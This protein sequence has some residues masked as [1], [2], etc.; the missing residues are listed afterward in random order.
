[1]KLCW[2]FLE[3]LASVAA[4][5]LIAMLLAVEIT[6][7]TGLTARA[8][9]IALDRVLPEGDWVVDA[10][11]LDLGGPSIEI[12]GLTWSMD[13][14]ELGRA[15]R[16]A[17][18]LSPFGLGRPVLERVV[19]RGGR[20][21]LSPALVAALTPR[22]GTADEDGGARPDQLAERA[23]LEIYDLELR[24]AASDTPL[25]TLDLRLD[26]I[27]EGRLTLVASARDR[28]GRTGRLEGRG[29]LYDDG[30]STIDVAADDLP[31]TPIG[32]IFEALSAHSKTERAT[33]PAFE[34]TGRLS[35][36][37]RAR[38]RTDR[39]DSI[40]LSFEAL[41][42]AVDASAPELDLTEGAVKGRLTWRPDETNDLGHVDG[43]IQGDVVWDGQRVRIGWRG[44]D[45]MPGEPDALAAPFGDIHLCTL[46]RPVGATV[47]ALV[48]RIVAG[49]Q[50]VVDRTFEA[51]GA[52]GAADA[53]LGLR[54]R[55]AVR[56][57]EM[58][59]TWTSDLALV[60][61]PNG[62]LA[63]SIDGWPNA[64][65]E[66][67]GFP[68]PVEGLEG[69][70]VYG[71]VGDGVR[72][73][74]LGVL[75]ADGYVPAAAGA[76]RPDART[77][78]VHVEGWLASPLPPD[79]RGNRAAD[80]RAPMHF[81][82]A[83]RDVPI[84]ERLTAAVFATGAGIDLDAIVGPRAGRVAEARVEIE[85]SPLLEGVVVSVD[86]T[87]ADLAGHLAEDLI[88][89]AFDFEEVDGNV[90]VRMGASTGGLGGD[91]DVERRAFGFALDLDG[92]FVG[93]SGSNIE[94]TGALRSADPLDPSA[95]LGGTLAQW[96]VVADGLSTGDE[97]LAP[98]LDADPTLRASLDEFGLEARLEV[99]FHSGV[100]RFGGAADERIEVRATGLEA[101]YR[102]VALAGPS[103]LDPNCAQVVAT[104]RRARGDAESAV[105]VQPWE[106]R[107]AAAARDEL[108]TDWSLRGETGPNGGYTAHVRV[109][110]LRPTDPTYLA[111]LD[112]EPSFEVR[113]ALDG[114]ARVGSSP[115]ADLRLEDAE[116]RLRGNDVDAGGVEITDL[117]GAL[118]LV[119]G[120]VE[121]DAIDG[122]LAN[123]PFTLRDVRLIL[124][125]NG[126]AAATSMSLP[127]GA[128]GR[129]IEVR[130]TARAFARN[131]RLDP[132]ELVR[133]DLEVARW[134]S[135]H[136][137]R[138]L[139]DVE[140]VELAVGLDVDGTPVT[141]ARGVLVP[142]DLYAHYSLP[143]RLRS[144]RLEVD[145][146]VADANG[147][148]AS[149]RLVDAYGD[150][151]EQSLAR[152]SARIELD[153]E[154]LVI[155]ELM[156][157]LGGG[158]IVGLSTAT[159]GNDQLIEG[160]RRPGASGTEALRLEFGEVSSFLLGLRL[161]RVDVG[162]L[163]G[164]LFGSQVQSRGKLSGY[165]Q[166]ARGRDDRLSALRGVAEVRLDEARLW[167]VPVVR[168]VFAVLGLDATATFDWMSTRLDLRGG[169]LYL[170]DAVARSPLVKLMGDGYVDADG[171][172]DQRFDLHYSLVDRVP[173]LSQLFYWFQSRLVSIRIGGSIDRPRI[174]LASVVT[175]LFRGGSNGKLQLPLPPTTPLPERF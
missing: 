48:G 112:V 53:W 168:E 110:G 95:T 96:D 54:I 27:E 75:G 132:R 174:E 138:G 50:D 144:A 56:R 136:R 102:G 169:R 70:V 36:R 153:G 44:G 30:E 39:V 63:M 119:A 28:Q 145:D 29:R 60:G 65:G 78:R 161:D 59:P 175:A 164:R 101:A 26:V 158:T 109:A 84:D 99:Q 103:V 87:V 51:L 111:A 121:S 114:W 73:D 20:L 81:K 72:H 118:H 5:V 57:D 13:G 4:L 129:P 24:T 126:S 100:A 154:R 47:Q 131:L 93:R 151:A 34:S 127:D 165:V 7:R 148:R 166:L 142:H 64:D 106:V 107:I 42:L 62:A 156:G 46:D 149:A 124:D 1:M 80:R 163:I 2:R 6:E 8:V 37:A 134:A 38:G 94:V 25:A 150:V 152:T 171:T 79:A 137:W 123:S 16:A 41:D 86:A 108:G 61:R 3:R 85:Q 11:R 172:L 139:I 68:L 71:H 33:L 19:V 67:S 140:G 122:R 162:D 135:E 105:P 155:D 104:R 167:S 10:C 157:E 133:D 74:R 45:Q 130:L 113:G 170:K 116:A 91:D 115:N 89:N 15:E 21:T 88:G 117:E 9:E 58:A 77:A 43:R 52:K 147:V 146:L 76:E 69:R 14:D 90:V 141:R 17:V 12:D 97:L 23:R 35:V 120:R 173:L 160:S 32:P 143:I 18:T 82:I 31:F 128:D 49:Q 83:A 55:R 125:P 98:Y 22:A 66:L 159:M 92:A 40:D